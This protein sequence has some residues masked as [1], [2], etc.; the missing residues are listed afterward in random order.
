MSD[1]YIHTFPGGTAFVGEDAI[2]LYSAITLRSAIKLYLKT[3]IMMT[4]GATITS[5]LRRTGSFTGKTYRRG[6]GEAA[7][8]DL[9]AWINAMQSALP[10]TADPNT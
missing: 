3:G 6:H 9:T 2:S 4:R 8:A 5:L 1:S 10:V 7:M